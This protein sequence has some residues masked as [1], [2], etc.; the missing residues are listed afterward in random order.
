M[1][2]IIRTQNDTVMVFDRTGEQMPKYQGHYQD[3]R[4]NI[5]RN[6]PPGAVFQHWSDRMPQAQPVPREL[7]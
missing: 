2:I 5:L 4:A 1:K 3:V 7:W 6:A